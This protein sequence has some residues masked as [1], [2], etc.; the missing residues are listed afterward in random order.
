MAQNNH[1][2]AISSI[3]ADVSLIRFHITAFK[4][5]VFT[6]N[7]SLFTNTLNIE[8]MIENVATG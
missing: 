4:G 2:L 7:T 6:K 8:A 5:I 1:C 3:I